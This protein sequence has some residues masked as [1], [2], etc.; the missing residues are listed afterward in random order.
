MPNAM[1]EP[2]PF[3]WI[4]II[5][6]DLPAAKAFFGALLGWTFPEMPGMGFLIEVDGHRQGAA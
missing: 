4:N 5:S 1:R 2:G 3:C 6:P